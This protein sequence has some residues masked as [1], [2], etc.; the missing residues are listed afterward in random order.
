MPKKNNP[1]CTCCSG[2]PLC[3]SLDWD[4]TDQGFIDG[5]QDGAL[6]SYDEPGDVSA[7]PWSYIVDSCC[8]R[9]DFENSGDDAVRSEDGGIHPNYPSPGGPGCDDHNPYRQIAT[10]STSITLAA[11][12]VM[13]I[14]FD[15][16]G[17]QEDTGFENIAIDV[18]GSP[19]ASATSPGG[20]LGCAEM[21]P[22]IPSASP[23]IEVALAAGAHTIDITADS[24]DNWYH[25]DAYYQVCISFRDP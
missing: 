5:G 11:D 15:G 21:A 16:I 4:F 2:D 10:A 18:D 25:V 13:V 17:E 23:P 20:N 12:K 7:S 6:R 22:V 1:G 8:L 24:G 9:V 14:E 19:V 3:S